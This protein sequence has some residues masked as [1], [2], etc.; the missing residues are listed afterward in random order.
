MLYS[1][2]GVIGGLKLFR[3]TGGGIVVIHWKLL[4][5]LNVKLL[6]NARKM[7]EVNHCIILLLL[8]TNTFLWDSSNVKGIFWTNPNLN[9]WRSINNRKMIINWENSILNW[10]ILL[11][12]LEALNHSL[13]AIVKLTELH[14]KLSINTIRFI[15][16]CNFRFISKYLSI[17]YE[18]F[19]EN[20]AR[21]HFTQE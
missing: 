3:G 17:A 6:N 21:S 5:F 16:F 19:H 7:N 2:G 12:S 13:L 10:K 1:I 9:K 20:E 11:C 4:M 15:Q 8:I 18:F 14:L